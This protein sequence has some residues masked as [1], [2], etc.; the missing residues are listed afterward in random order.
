MTAMSFDPI[1]IYYI[2]ALISVPILGLIYTGLTEKWYWKGWKDG[3]KFAENGR[4][5]TR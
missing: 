5:H 2:I 1:A 3:R 4:E